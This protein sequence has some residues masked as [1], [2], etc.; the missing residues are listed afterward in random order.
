MKSSDITEYYLDSALFITI[1]LSSPESYYSADDIQPCLTG[2]SLMD[3]WLRRWRLRDMK[4]TAH[5]HGLEPQ[6]GQT[7]GA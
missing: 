1:I 3:E 5:G 4:C 2:W 7:W 6:L